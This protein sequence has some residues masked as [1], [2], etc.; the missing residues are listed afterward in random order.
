MNPTEE[1]SMIKDFIC[2]KPD[3]VTE[4]N[5][6]DNSCRDEWRLRAKRISQSSSLA[7]IGMAF[8]SRIYLDAGYR[9]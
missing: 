3:S 1:P 2:K 9:H 8:Y 5:L 7:Q 6:T 4:R